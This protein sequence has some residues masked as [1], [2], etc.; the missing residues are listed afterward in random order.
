MNAKRIW[1]D[2]Q[3]FWQQHATPLQQEIIFA[4]TGTK[5]PADDPWKYVAAFAGSDIE[6]NPPETN[7]AVQASG[8]QFSRQ[9]DQLPDPEVLDEI[10]RRLD[11]QHMEATLMAEGREEVC[12][13]A[14]GAACR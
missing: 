7:E 8:R 5:D 3:A 14:E 10:D 12:R 11:Q 4:S 13:P 9:I 2:N 6:T 1:A